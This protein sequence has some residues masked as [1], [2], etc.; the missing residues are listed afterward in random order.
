RAGTITWGEVLRWPEHVSKTKDGAGSYVF[1]ELAVCRCPDCGGKT[2]KRMRNATSVINRSVLTL[3][4]DHPAEDFI[5]AV[6]LLVPW[7]GLVHTTFS[8]APDEPRYRILLPLS[9]SVAPDEYHALAS[10]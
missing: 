8:S 9:R 2:E 3:D 6:E 10:I 5:D 7:A 1:G 4:V